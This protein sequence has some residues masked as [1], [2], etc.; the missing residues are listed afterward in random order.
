MAWLMQYPKGYPYDK[1]IIPLNLYKNQ[2]VYIGLYK[3][4]IVDVILVFNI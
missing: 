4:N 1:F 2:Y 3:L